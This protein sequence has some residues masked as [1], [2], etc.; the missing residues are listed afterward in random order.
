MWNYHVKTERWKKKTHGCIKALLK[1]FRRCS[2]MFE[3]ICNFFS[4]PNKK[5]NQMKFLDKNVHEKVNKNNWKDG[6]RVEIRGKICIF[7][8][9]KPKWCC[10]Q[11]ER[12][13]IRQPLR[14][15][16]FFFVAFSKLEYEL[17][18]DETQLKAFHRFNLLFRI[19]K[20]HADNL[21]NF[22]AILIWFEN[23]AILREMI[24]SFEAFLN[25]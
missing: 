4:G 25:F 19:K 9:S 17:C 10:S 16:L 15:V 12:H 18:R 21:T 8:P 7:F 6:I 23:C 14:F 24:W 11:C 13:I 22:F 3:V 1:A 2:L 20:K 5:A